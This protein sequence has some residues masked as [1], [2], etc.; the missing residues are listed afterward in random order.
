MSDEN[1]EKKRQLVQQVR[2]RYSENQSEMYNRERFYIGESSHR[3]KMEKG[4]EEC[5]KTR[6]NSPFLK[7][8]FLFALLFFLSIVIMDTNNIT[9]A[10]IT[11]EKIYRV[12]SADYV[13]KIEVW[14]ETL[15]ASY[16]NPQR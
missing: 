13:D 1:I 4:D 16:N 5:M 9:V 10:G 15:A 6:G 2:S 3:N 7:I 11:V 12:I 8:R 14:M